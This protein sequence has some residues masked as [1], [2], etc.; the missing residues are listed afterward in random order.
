[1]VRVAIPRGRVDF[2]SGACRLSRAERGGR[3]AGLCL[4]AAIGD[5][6]LDYQSHPLTHRSSPTSVL[7]SRPRLGMGDRRGITQKCN[8]G[9][10]SCLDD[11]RPARKELIG[12][13]H[14]LD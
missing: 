7:T 5:S 6:L 8:A 14:L 3:P 2:C 4:P 9:W 13:A 1:M 10:D 12:Q 11:A